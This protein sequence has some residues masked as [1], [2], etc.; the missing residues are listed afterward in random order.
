KPNKTEQSLNSGFQQYY[1]TDVN[2]S[3][4]TDSDST[5]NRP[6]KTAQSLKS[7]L[8]YDDSS[9]TDSDS[10]II[11]SD[12]PKPSI[13]PTNKCFWITGIAFIAVAGLV[14]FHVL[15]KQNSRS[16]VTND[17]VGL[18]KMGRSLDFFETF[19]LRTPN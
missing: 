2:D 5:D 6:N 12:E 16:C 18:E 17:I 10:S 13:E 4:S 8:L 19:F 11:P 3:S 1:S 14:A 7:G 15:K 9:S